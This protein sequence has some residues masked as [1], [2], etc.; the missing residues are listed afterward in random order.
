M[1][2]P[3][4]LA[5]GE[6]ICYTK[7]I[8]D[9][10]ETSDAMSSLIGTQKVS[11]VGQS[12]LRVRTIAFSMACTSPPF[13]ISFYFIGSAITCYI[14]WYNNYYTISIMLS[15]WHELAVDKHLAR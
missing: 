13:F 12:N 14:L 7:Q 6:A 11:N 10:N 1:L 3:G 4:A 15:H 8:F 2:N 9:T 5:H